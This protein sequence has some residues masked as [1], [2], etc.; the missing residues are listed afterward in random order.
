MMQ[1]ALA[2]PVEQHD[3]NSYGGMYD[4]TIRYSDSPAGAAEVVAAADKGQIEL[5]N[6][7]HRD[8]RMQIPGI[9]GGWMI[10]VRPPA[11][12]KRLL[13]DLRS[14]FEDLEAAGTRVFEPGSSDPSEGA[15]E[16]A[17]ANGIVQAWQ[18]GTDFPGSV[19]FTFDIEAVF[20]GTA[21]MLSDWSS[22][23]LSSPE[24]EDVRKKLAGSG[25]PERHA[26][27]LIPPFSTAPEAVVQLLLEDSPFVPSK[28][29]SLPTEITHVWLATTWS[30]GLGIRWAPNTGWSHFRKEP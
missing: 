21:D 11:R 3:D 7:L 27:V 10:T 24:T 26:F 17:R 29:P 2:V 1:T 18:S 30:T 4:L 25:A 19:Y 5:W 9:T 23:Y 15:T 20:I 28:R 12:A 14:F 8:G 6:V 13:T 16:L 22:R